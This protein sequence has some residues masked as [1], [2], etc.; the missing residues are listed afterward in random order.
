MVWVDESRNTTRTMKRPT[1]KT[2]AVRSK[3]KQ[4]NQNGTPDELEC[5]NEDVWT[6]TADGKNGR[7]ECRKR[8][9]VKV[10]SS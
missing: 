8:Y 9:R 7:I 3:P 5:P 4:D 1:R 10:R 6:N 2:G